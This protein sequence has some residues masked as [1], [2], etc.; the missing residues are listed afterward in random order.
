MATNCASGQHL[1][2]CS[3][4]TMHFHPVPPTFTGWST[5]PSSTSCGTHPLSVAEPQ[6]SLTRLLIWVG[7]YWRRKRREV[8]VAVS[9]WMSTRRGV[10]ERCATN[11]E[12]TI[13]HSPRRWRRKTHSTCGTPVWMPHQTGP[14][15]SP[16]L[17]LDVN[18]LAWITM[19]FQVSAPTATTVANKEE[20]QDVPHRRN[21]LPLQNGRYLCFLLLHLKSSGLW[22]F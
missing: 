8:C 1:H 17:S 7:G 3:T 2:K 9:E 11:G 4:G 21:S 18:K 10:G 15:R 20:N 16:C 13:A 19:Y 22:H 12:W 6:P 14:N 5:L